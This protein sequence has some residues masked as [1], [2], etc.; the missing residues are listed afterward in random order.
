[1]YCSFYLLRPLVCGINLGFGTHGVECAWVGGKHVV[2]SCLDNLME[3]GGPVESECIM[4]RK[5]ICHVRVFW[6][7]SVWRDT[8]CS[9]WRSKRTALILMCCVWIPNS[10]F[11]IS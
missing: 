6:V 1:M 11:I 8:V 2:V 7:N 9:V 5:M 10:V 3:E 4:R